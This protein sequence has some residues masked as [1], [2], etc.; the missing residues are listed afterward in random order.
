[1][2][3]PPEIVLL[4]RSSDVCEIYLTNSAS[5]SLRGPIDISAIPVDLGTNSLIVINAVSQLGSLWAAPRYNTDHTVFSETTETAVQNHLI[6]LAGVLQKERHTQKGQRFLFEARSILDENLQDAHYDPLPLWQAWWTDRPTAARTSSFNLLGTLLPEMNT[7]L[8]KQIPSHLLQAAKAKATLP[9]I[10]A[11]LETA[12]TTSIPRSEVGQVIEA[13]ALPFTV[14]EIITLALEAYEIEDQN[15][16]AYPKPPPSL[17]QLAIDMQKL[18]EAI[19]PAYF[20]DPRTT[21]KFPNQ[22]AIIV[23]HERM[24]ELAI[25]HGNKDQ[26]T[27][28]AEV[29]N[30]LKRKIF[31]EKKASRPSPEAVKRLLESPELLVNPQDYGLKVNPHLTEL[32]RR[33]HENPPFNR[34]SQRERASFLQRI[35]VVLPEEI[36][37]NPEGF[38]AYQRALVLEIA[39]QLEI[40]VDP[41]IEVPL[42][43]TVRSNPEAQQVFR[44]Q[45]RLIKN[46]GDW[47]WLLLFEDVQEAFLTMLP[48]ACLPP[49]AVR[50]ENSNRSLVFPWVKANHKTKPK[51]HLIYF[52]NPLAALHH[53]DEQ[54][55]MLQLTLPGEFNLAV[56]ESGGRPFIVHGLARALF[57]LEKDIP[58][59]SEKYLATSHENPPSDVDEC[60][61]PP[62]PRKSLNYDLGVLAKR[63]CDRH[64]GHALWSDSRYGLSMRSVR[65]VEI[66]KRLPGGDTFFR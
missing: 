14:G 15:S 62:H 25:L 7:C 59:G 44:E 28:Y 17:R 39:R 30:N 18:V 47:R 66:N 60:I 37:R 48:Y 61:L 53:W 58:T 64:R 57:G 34:W 29:L 43:W 13:R 31:I 16:L 56:L 52:H 35:V 23:F 4:P 10:Q 6:N 42:P 45:E 50:E 54:R 8:T 63:T 41:T 40:P 22:D 19:D 9:Y 36:T 33:H 32:L 49:V 38:Q 5:G 51:D 2:P 21:T 24:N 1:M 12:I 11:A 26:A 46:M 20:T 27:F 3:R 65:Y 55:Q